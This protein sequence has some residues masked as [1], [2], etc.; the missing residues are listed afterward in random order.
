MT[1]AVSFIFVALATYWFGFKEGFFSGVV[2]LACVVVAGALAF[3]FW[4][5][6]AHA[7][8]GVAALREWS[9]GLSLLGIFCIS[10]LALRI[11]ANLLI[12]DRQNFPQAVDVTGGCATGLA[13]GMITAGVGLIGIGFLPIG[14]L[15]GGYVRLQSKAGQPGLKSQL[16][17]PASFTEA[18]YGS[19]SRGAFAP[20]TNRDG[21]AVAYPSLTQQA[22]GLQRDTADKGRIELTAAPGDLTVGTPFIGTFPGAPT[23]GE[24]A[25]VPVSVEKEGF[26]QGST[27]ILSSS[28]ARLIGDGSTPAYAFPK[29]WREGGKNYLFDGMTN[30][31]TNVPGEQSINLL[32]VFDMAD[33]AGQEPKSLM[34]K[35]LRLPLATA[36]TNLADLPLGGGTSRVAY[37]TNAPRIPSNF[38]RV[39][40]TLGVTINKNS[41]PAGMDVEAGAI[42][43]ASGLDIP[44]KLSGTVNKSLRVDRLYELP[45]TRLVKLDVSRGQSPVDIWGDVRKSEG[46]NAALVLVDAD[47]GTFTPVGWLHRQSSIGMINVKLDARTGVPTI[48]G[49]PMLSSAG[50]DSLDL[51]F[52]IPAGRKI[53][54]VK[55]G[56]TTLGTVSLDVKK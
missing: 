4:E 53:V 22:W 40:P 15:G 10:L 31:A 8:L 7:L 18:F 28:Q 33:L 32:L 34:F 43:Q 17:F 26:H 55:L 11:A 16:P 24:Y 54:A 41:L 37:D 48:S 14:D 47:G 49:V 12:P 27:F 9:W 21:L 50:K 19:L 25:V 52:S 51:L 29:G 23:N 56:E 1:L 6:L 3:A 42:T 35:G 46:E 30:F 44:S 39:D 20:M 13:T 38:L 5:P 36:S 45:G 2:H